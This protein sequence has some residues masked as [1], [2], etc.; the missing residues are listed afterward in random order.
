MV[1]VFCET[2]EKY[3][4]VGRYQ[5]DGVSGKFNGGFYYYSDRKVAGHLA[6]ECAGVSVEKMLLGLHSPEDDS[7]SFIQFSDLKTLP[8][9][10]TT[11]RGAGRTLGRLGENY[12][13]FWIF[14]ADLYVP[15]G[16][17]SLNKNEMP[18]LNDIREIPAEELRES[19]FN[20]EMIEKTKTNAMRHALCGAINL[21]LEQ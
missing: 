17:D 15:V 2:R 10:W 12:G 21:R 7:L 5:G 9:L 20:R 18:R 13:G 16:L 8:I 11:R 1:S 19:Y 3:S 4:I 14:L 6:D